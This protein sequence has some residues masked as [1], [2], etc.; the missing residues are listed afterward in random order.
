M[1]LPFFSNR[2]IMLLQKR[3][4][5]QIFEA[6]QSVGLNPQEF[7]FENRGT[8]TRLKHKWS[9]SYFVIGGNAGHYVGRYVVGDAID[10][11]YEVYS[12][13]P[14]MSRFSG[15]VKDVKDDLDTPDL[16]AELQRDARLLGG[17]SGEANKNTPFTSEEQKDIEERLR[18][19]EAHVRNTY[20]LTESDFNLLHKKIDYL[21]DAAGRL[22]RIDWLNACAGALFGFILS[23]GLP[24]ESIRPFMTDLLHHLFEHGLPQLPIGG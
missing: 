8:E 11:P 17:V 5:N 1:G 15:W 10:W 22:N 12:W 3:R 4:T 2:K 14:V 16:W 20:S 19:V 7:E 6:I 24:P 13:E 23:V 18:E 21:V 9:K